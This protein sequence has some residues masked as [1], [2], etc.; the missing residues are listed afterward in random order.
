MSRVAKVTISL[1]A[2]TLDAVERRRAALQQSR[3]EYI[4]EAVVRALR[5]EQEEQDIQRYLEG[6]RRLPESD[7]EVQAAHALASAVLAQEPW[8]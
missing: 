3:S 1:D 8:G 4:R 5:D 7:E 6:Y 2:E